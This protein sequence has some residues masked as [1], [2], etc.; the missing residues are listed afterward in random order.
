MQSFPAT[1]RQA[2]KNG[3]LSAKSQR[4]Y[5]RTFPVMKQNPKQLTARNNKTQH[6]SD[7]DETVPASNKGAK[8]DRGNEA[9]ITSIY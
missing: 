4:K 6:K 3:C 9:Y 7:D 1:N 8:G 5:A 2:L